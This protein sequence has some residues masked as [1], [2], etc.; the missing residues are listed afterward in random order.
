MS[1]RDPRRA[2]AFQAIVEHVRS[3]EPGTWKAIR[4]RFPDIPEATFFRYVRKAR[5]A[6]SGEVAVAE[7]RQ[8]IADHVGAVASHPDVGAVQPDINGQGSLV[9]SEALGFR[10]LDLLRRVDEVFADIELLRAYAMGPEG[11]IRAPLFWT[12]AISLKDR[13]IGTALKCASAALSMERVIDFMDD[14]VAEVAAES[15]EAARKIIVR[16]TRF[17]AS[18]GRDGGYF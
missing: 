15:P 16:L 10:Q 1:D 4:D 3:A 17:S 11:K 9:P 13:S 5:Q 6:Q 12:Q 14:V 8:R 7:A 2:E 18:G